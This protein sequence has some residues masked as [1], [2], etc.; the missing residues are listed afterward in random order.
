MS[1]VAFV[2]IPVFEVGFGDALVPDDEEIFRVG[3]L[4]GLGEVKRAGD[5]CFFVD[6]NDF[7]VLYG[8]ACVDPSGDAGVCRE[9][10]GRVFLGALA[11]VE[12]DCHVD[13][14]AMGVDQGLGDGC[15]GEGVDHYM[16]GFL[17]GVDFVDD[18]LGDVSL[19][20]EID[21]RSWD[22]SLGCCGA[23]EAGFREENAGNEDEFSDVHGCLVGCLFQDEFDVFVFEVC[24]GIWFRCRVGICYGICYW[25][26]VPPPLVCEW[27]CYCFSKYFAA[28]PVDVGYGCCVYV[29]A[30]VDMAG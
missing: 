27:V 29:F 2:K 25:F 7:V 23:C 17:G 26:W 20:A 12:D 6:D 28:E 10:C 24:Y 8:M 18:G 15:G 19:W 9:I 14:A 21:F 30:V 22:V 13:V 11:F 16:D 4:C 1:A 5:Y 3:F